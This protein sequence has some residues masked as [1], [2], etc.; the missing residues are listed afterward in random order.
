[1]KKKYIYLPFIPIIYCM[2]MTACNTANTND[3]GVV[4]NGVTWATRNVNSVGTFTGRAEDAGMMYQ[5]NTKTAWNAT[6]TVSDWNTTMPSGTT[7]ERENDPSPAGWRVPTLAEIQSLLDT[8]K[9]LCTSTV[10]NGVKGSLFTDKTTNQSLFFPFAGYRYFTNGTLYYGGTL[11]VY[12][13]NTEEKAGGSLALYSN[14]AG[15]NL[16]GS[17]RTFAYTIRP[18][19]ALREPQ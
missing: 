12:W 1:M 16:N 4:I 7:W 19:A 18:V 10:Q 15:N 14:I 13:I 5:W 11:G 9:V 8:T 6:G 3:A 2:C 17:R